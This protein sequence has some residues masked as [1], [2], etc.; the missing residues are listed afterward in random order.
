VAENAK[1][2][3]DHSPGARVM[4][5]I[6]HEII[7]ATIVLTLQR[8]MHEHF[9]TISTLSCMNRTASGGNWK[10]DCGT[11]C[12]GQLKGL[13]HLHRLDELLSV[14]IC[15]GLFGKRDR[16]DEDSVK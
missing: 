8:I 13:G 12:T 15:E 9:V 1:L 7:L 2:S 5:E 4:H 10:I 16:T 14:M 6:M 3:C 11:N